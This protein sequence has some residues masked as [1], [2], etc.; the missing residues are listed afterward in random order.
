VG[1]AEE[2]SWGVRIRDAPATLVRLIRAA[3]R[4]ART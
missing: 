1:S 4:T 2:V 3:I